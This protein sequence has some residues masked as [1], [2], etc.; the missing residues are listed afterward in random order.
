MH[1][2]FIQNEIIKRSGLV[3]YKVPFHDDVDNAMIIK[4]R[5]QF[6]LLR[7]RATCKHYAAASNNAVDVLDLKSD[8]WSAR[9]LYMTTLSHVIL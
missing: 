6:I 9:L 3:I 1:N 7:Q 5:L 4:Y 8:P 2:L